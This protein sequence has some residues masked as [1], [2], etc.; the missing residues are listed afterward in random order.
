MPVLIALL[1]LP[2]SEIAL[3]IV[4]GG[5]IGLW[6]TLALVL[7]AAIAGVLILRRP[8]VVHLPLRGAPGAGLLSS[9]MPVAEGAARVLAGVLLIVPGFLTDGLAL[10]LLV[11]PVRRALIGAIGRW[12]TAHATGAPEQSI[13]IEG[14]FVDLES[15]KADPHRPPLTRH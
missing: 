14:E 15:G 13:I 4:V 6:P 7:I 8:G 5:W 9:L 12:M 10:A 2:L 11:P 3:F 1:V